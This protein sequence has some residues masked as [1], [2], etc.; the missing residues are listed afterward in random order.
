MNMCACNDSQVLL[1]ISTSWDTSPAREAVQIVTR[2]VFVARRSSSAGMAM[3]QTTG[4][5]EKGASRASV[6]L[7]KRMT[8][9]SATYSK[10]TL[11]ASAMRMTEAR[12]RDVMVVGTFYS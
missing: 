9:D 7:S 2:G 5:A 6:H 8:S 12:L 3:C 4:I 10:T 11:T 1:L